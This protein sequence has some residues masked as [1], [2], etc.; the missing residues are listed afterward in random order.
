MTDIPY[1]CVII[2]AYN[3]EKYI[4]R[5]IRSVLHQ[6]IP[7]N[8][9]EII[10][11]NDSSFD[12]T[13]FALEIFEK[14][15][16]VINNKKRL[17]LPKSLNKGILKARGKYIV[18]IDGDDYVNHDFLKI[19]YLHLEMNPEIDAISCDYLIVDDNENVLAKKNCMDSPIACGIMF[20][21]EHLIGIGLYDEKFILREDEDLRIRFLKKY[22]IRR[23]GL[24]LYRYRRHKDNM[25]NNI[26]KMHRYKQLLEHKHRKRG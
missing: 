25:T 8:D 21:L 16:H 19:L 4:G 17:G 24:P 6:S 7:R 11:I 22:D 13:N 9:Y 5:C 12:R 23:V 26:Q 10:V 14:D 15:I 20:R 2:T 1:I 18:R 3:V